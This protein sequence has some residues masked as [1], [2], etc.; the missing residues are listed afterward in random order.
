M[1]LIASANRHRGARLVAALLIFVAIALAGILPAVAQRPNGAGLVIRF[2]DGSVIYAYV[3]FEEETISSEELLYR[4][5]LAVAIAPY[6]GLGAGVCMID[7]EGCP[8]DDCFCQSY[9]TPAYFWHFY[10]NDG[11]WRELLQ[12]A[13]SRSVGDGDIDGWS[14]TAGDSG[15]PAVTIDEIALLNGVDRNPPP[16]TETP[17]P[18]PTSTPFPTDTPQPT[19]TQPPPPT[20]TPVNTP[21]E[22]GEPTATV[23]VPATATASP[24][25]PTEAGQAAVTATR[26]REPDPTATRTQT[27]TAVAS[28][29]PPTLTLV[30]SAT[31]V[32][33]LV[34]PDGTAVPVEVVRADDGTSS[35][36]LLLFGGLV[37][38]ATGAGAFVW[39][40][41]RRSA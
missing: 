10:A 35:T 11:G 24:T 18:E 30:A 15:L 8:S 7:G 26:T 38:V 1:N 39:V 33:V 9:T 22:A 23:A 12:G 25:P 36:N 17:T 3:Q 6:S 4:S 21:T 32:A 19:A 16:P 27:P 5:G 13:S 40:R 37:A 41:G 28:S 20:N 2:G 29:P 34:Q 14:W 31:T